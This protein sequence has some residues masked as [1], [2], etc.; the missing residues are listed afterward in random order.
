MYTGL[1]AGT[2]TVL[3][4]DPEQE[5]YRLRIEPNGFVAP[6]PGDSVSVQGVCLTADR[7]GD[8]W[9]TAFCSET[10]LAKS[11]LGSLEPGDAV[12]LESPVA[13]GDALDGHLVRG[14]VKTTTEVLAV[15]STGAGWRY[16]LAIPDGFAGYL[17][18]EGPI[19]VDGVSLTVAELT[20]QTVTITV[21]PETAERTTLGDTEPG[22]RVNL[23]SD[24]VAKYVARQEAVA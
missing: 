11:T 3:A 24:P 20:E 1:V 23:E 14:C 21:I 17:V 13:A 4:A 12:N 9:F 22:D 6:E 7:V 8:G 5:G 19:T 16:T 2:G 10:T 18:T 15:E